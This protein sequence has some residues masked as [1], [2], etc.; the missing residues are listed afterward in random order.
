[1][2]G[3]EWSYDHTVESQTVFALQKKRLLTSDK[4]KTSCV[5]FWFIACCLNC[6]TPLTECVFNL[7]KLFRTLQRESLHPV[8]PTTTGVVTWPVGCKRPCWKISP[9]LSW[10]QDSSH[11]SSSFTIE[12]QS[13]SCVTK[14]GTWEL[15]LEVSGAPDACL[16][17]LSPSL[18]YYSFLLKLYISILSGIF[19]VHSTI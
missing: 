18:P 11:I 1:M 8:K 5:S 12:R 19:W 13:T 4:K 6:E 2:H 17:F 15:H 14:E 16:C 3:I 7:S 10:N 9:K